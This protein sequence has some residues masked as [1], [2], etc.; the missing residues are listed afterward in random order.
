MATKA[1]KAK[2]SLLPRI[3]SNWGCRRNSAENM[4]FGRKLEICKFDLISAK[5]LGRN[6]NGTESFSLRDTNKVITIT[7]QEKRTILAMSA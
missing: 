7:S 4:A 1:K 2:V 5:S 3:G 6:G